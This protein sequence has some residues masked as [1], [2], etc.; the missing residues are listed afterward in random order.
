MISDR[1]SAVL[2]RVRMLRTTSNSTAVD[3]KM[4]RN[5]QIIVGHHNT[6]V[7]ISLLCLQ[8]NSREPSIAM[9][10]QLLFS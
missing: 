5:K 9:T 10:Y 4:L 2:V 7:A 8:T 3:Q 6:F 1:S